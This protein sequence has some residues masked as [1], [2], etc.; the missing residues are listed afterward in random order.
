MMYSALLPRIAG[1]WSKRLSLGI[2]KMIHRRKN[3]DKSTT[4]W[5]WAH[6]I[7]PQDLTSTHVALTQH[8]PLAVPKITLRRVMFL[9]HSH[10]QH[11]LDF[12]H[13]IST[14]VPGKQI[15]SFIVLLED[16]RME[17]DITHVKCYVLG[18]CTQGALKWIFFLKDSR[19][20]AQHLQRPSGRNL[21]HPIYHNIMGKPAFIIATCWRPP[22]W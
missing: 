11:P 8:P 21:G 9:L 14:L 3:Y 12:G 2:C 18:F 13:N 16:R 20:S 5:S 15:T 10:R 17:M 7:F 4:H 19:P 22:L 1:L 6:N